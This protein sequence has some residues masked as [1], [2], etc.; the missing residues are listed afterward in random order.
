[1][2]TSPGDQ[3]FTTSWTLHRLS[4]LYHGKECQTLLDNPNG[5]KLY[6]NRLREL[7][8]GDVFRGVQVGIEGLG[9]TDDAVSKAGPLKACK[10]EILPTWGHWNEEESLLLEEDPEKAASVIPPDVSAGILVT[11][12]YENITYKAAMLTGPDGYH[13]T[14]KGVTFLPLLLTRLPNSLRQTFVS[15]LAMN[16]D[17]RCSILR[18]PSSFLC[19]AFENYLAILHGPTSASR[20]G[21]APSSSREFVEKVIKESQLTLSFPAPVSS[22][23]KSL[24]VLIPRES[25]SAFFIYGSK[26]IENNENRA[27]NDISRNRGKKR[28]H[29]DTTKDENPSAPFLAALSEYFDTNLAMKLDIRDSFTND[30]K[31][32]QAKHVR[33]SKISCGAFVLGG[34]GRMKLLANPGRVIPFDEADVEEG[35]G[36]DPDSR[37]I[38]LVWRA[39]EALL[40][41]LVS[42]AVGGQSE[43]QN[44][45]LGGG[46]GT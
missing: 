12:D 23:L 40:R 4:P 35:E 1:M 24:D 33:L 29:A 46:E 11:L 13:D 41:A 10:W 7:L 39:N 43:R 27:A 32:G 3:L 37:E 34:E 38:R 9:A 5:L 42:R 17:S 25:L 14:Q 20:A 31:N 36:D 45:G 8:R 6:A 18:L 19:G 15:F 28:S 16:F 30:S 44:G 2:A 26:I 21:N 22:S